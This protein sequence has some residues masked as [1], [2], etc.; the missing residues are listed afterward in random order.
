MKIRSMSMMPIYRVRVSDSP[1]PERP[2][3]KTLITDGCG[4]W[5]VDWPAHGEWTWGYEKQI[6]GLEQ[7]F[8][9]QRDGVKPPVPLSFPRLPSVH[10]PDWDEIKGLFSNR[11]RTQKDEDEAEIYLTGGQPSIEKVSQKVA[12]TFADGT[13]SDPVGYV[14]EIDTAARADLSI[15]FSRQ[16][17]SVLVGGEIAFVLYI[18]WTGSYL[19]VGRVCFNLERN[20]SLPAEEFVPDWSLEDDWAER[21]YPRIRHFYRRSIQELSEFAR[22]MGSHDGSSRLFQ[23]FRGYTPSIEKEIQRINKEI[24]EERE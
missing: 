11:T 22:V 9:D 5:A 3:V 13:Q 12:Y 19:S 2:D 6:G 17:G 15:S 8:Q 23:G 16:T 24:T 1:I 18:P 20:T 21:V 10:D 7:E 14:Y 4:N